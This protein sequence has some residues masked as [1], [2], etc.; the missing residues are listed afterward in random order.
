MLTRFIGNYREWLNLSLRQSAL[1]EIN[2][3]RSVCSRVMD[4]NL[5]QTGCFF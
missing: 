3:I 5:K 2:Y 4:S 1:L